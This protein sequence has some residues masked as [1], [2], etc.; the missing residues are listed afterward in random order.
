MAYRRS[1]ICA[2]IK[3][4]PDFVS[5]SWILITK[6]KQSNVPIFMVCLIKII[7]VHLGLKEI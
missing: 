3:V 4:I 2:G 1:A 5:H 7:T 6:G